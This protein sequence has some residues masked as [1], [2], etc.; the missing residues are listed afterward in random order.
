MKSYN[1]YEDTY[2]RKTYQYNLFDFF[3]QTKI[4]TNHKRIHTGRNQISASCGT[5]FFD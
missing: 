1:A 5:K 4:V 2:W 3:F